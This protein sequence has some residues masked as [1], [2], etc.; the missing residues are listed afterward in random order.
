MRASPEEGKIFV[1]GR[2]NFLGEHLDYN[3]GT[4][5][6][7]TLNL[8]LT[9]CWE[10]IAEPVVEIWSEGH[11]RRCII[12]LRE[13]WLHPPL[14]PWYRPAWAMLC[15]LVAR[16]PG[17]E[18]GFRLRISS[19]LPAGA[20]LSSSA[21]IE[22]LMGCVFAAVQEVHPELA[23]V[24]FAALEAEHHHL[25][26][27]CGIMDMWAIVHGK[28]GYLTAIDCNG[29]SHKLVPFSTGPFQPLI[30]N[31]RQPRTLAHSA[32]NDRRAACE[33]AL[34]ALQSLWSVPYL[35]AAL[36]EM[37]IAIP[38][39]EDKRR[40]RHVISE[41]RRVQKAIVCLENGNFQALGPLLRESHRSLA[42]DYQVT[43]PLLD[44]LAEWANS[45]EGCLG[46]RMTGAGF[47]GC[48]IALVHQDALPTFRK[49]FD[50]FASTFSPPPEL[51]DARPGEIN[52]LL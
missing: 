34:K 24:A 35:A 37:L 32:Y 26:V 14:D 46:C 23:D 39:E 17:K 5:L 29:P 7:F 51:L 18:R 28:K 36:P 49:K 4:V 47:G 40:A 10:T 6:P 22:V 31:S 12:P 15:V 9:G 48:L 11:P 42:E 41:N 33:R 38:S 50:A 2:I 20:G 43:T 21:A 16:Y 1:P 30:I 45:Q 3:G 8:G 44:R 19:T 27:R 25:G 52:F 13:T